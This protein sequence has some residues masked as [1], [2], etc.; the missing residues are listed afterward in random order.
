[1]KSSNERRSRRRAGAMPVRRRRGL[2]LA[3]ESLEDRALLAAMTFEVDTKLMGLDASKYSL[4]AMGSTFTASSATNWYMNES[5]S[6]V[7]GLPSEGRTHSYRVTDGSKISVLDDSIKGARIYFFV[8]PA[9]GVASAT[10]NEASFGYTGTTVDVTFSAPPA[11]GATAKGYA[12]LVASDHPTTDMNKVG[13]IVITD[14]GRGYTSPPTV[15]IAP[16]GVVDT[17]TVT[18]GGKD[19][20]NGQQSFTITSTNPL[21]PASVAVNVTGG[22]VPTGSATVTNRGGG[23][24]GAG[25]FTQPISISPS[26]SEG[27]ASV[28]LKSAATAT[29]T[30]FG[31]EG[32]SLP[33]AT[34][35]A[36][37]PDFPFVYQIVEFT[38]VTGEANT[39]DLQTVD[40]FTMPMT[41]TAGSSNVNDAQYQFGQPISTPQA[42]ANAAVT[43]GSILEA[44]DSFM[45][46]LGTAGQ[47]YQ[48]LPYVLPNG[49]IDG[50][51]GGILSPDLYLA[52]QS[53][54]GNYL[55]LGSALDTV[56]DEQLK[57]FFST[58]TD[59]NGKVGPLSVQGQGLHP[60]IYTG[61]YA[62]SVQYPGPPNAAPQTLHE[63][64]S[65]PIVHPAITFTG[66]DSRT[67]NVFSPIGLC[68][69]TDAAGNPLTGIVSAVNGAFPSQ[70][71]TIELE[72]PLPDDVQAGWFV[73]GSG[74]SQGGGNNQSAAISPW[75][76]SD[77]KPGRTT[78]S[79]AYT[80]LNGPVEGPAVQTT[81]ASQFQFSKLPYLSM[82][83]TPGQMAF[84]NSGVFADNT[85]QYDQNTDDAA[86]VANLE[87]QIAAA[88]NRGVLLAKS[89]STEPGSTSAT[90]FDETKW[91]PAGKA[92]NLFSYFM[93][94]GTV[95]DPQ[96]GDSVP[97][98]SRPVN[99][100]EIHGH[101]GV[102]KM[103]AA[104]GF[105]FDETP[106]AGYTQVPSKFD[107][108]IGGGQLPGDILVTFGPWGDVTPS[109]DPEVQA[110]GTF[111]IYA[112]TGPLAWTRAGKPLDV[113]LNVPSEEV[114]LVTMTASPT[115]AVPAPKFTWA[116]AAGVSATRV[117]DDR[118]IYL[119]GTRAAIVAALEQAVSPLGFD[120][121]VIPS[122]KTAVDLTISGWRK[123]ASSWTPF[124]TA[125]SVVSNVPVYPLVVDVPKVPQSAALDTP[126][127]L[128]LPHETFADTDPTANIHHIA[129]FSVS[130]SG[131]G[132][133]QFVYAS[134]VS[135]PSVTTWN[136]TGPMTG[137]TDGVAQSVSLFGTVEEI[138]RYVNAVGIRFKATR[139]GESKID[140][141][142]LRLAVSAT[143]GGWIVVDSK[144]D[145]LTVATGAA[146]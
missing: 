46:G 134:N 126:I 80:G 27:N 64:K 90:W 137:P 56:F 71:A 15:T 117:T 146:G 21:S 94:V 58:A 79:V 35:P 24:T 86:V 1:M 51:M 113:I 28:K 116:P 76:V 54:D 88:L 38:S 120:Y 68:R 139:D 105:P 25:S 69:L 112:E 75:Y 26:G 85:L 103:G 98:F 63:G 81:I 138:N 72:Q 39:V 107:Q 44:Y 83:L 53:V 111:K 13:S 10:V 8:V 42:P 73:F 2:A 141:T 93:H 118:V 135:G 123:P 78:V 48:K 40:G 109:T 4:Y 127:V 97:I 43:R 114:V 9:G 23:Y 82:M 124:D 18:D 29:A 106:G 36:N 102:A 55:H 31:N 70:T 115:S 133:G 108:N 3:V 132:T 30:L 84:G 144:T 16:P 89:A 45:E 6:F 74:L 99:P 91:Y 5:L 12:Q 104:Y 34:Q 131:G 11:G 61:T 92:Q 130:D 142:L 57:T 143:T 136:A 95:K 14:P 87:Y 119:Q 47:P 37:P 110:P 129:V 49:P 122:P 100:Q 52:A 128:D 77:V 41:I 65:V 66:A 22:A 19:Y 7:Q 125:F 62:A 145:E 101:Y 59:V 17:V 140:V 33:I 50:Q 67:F 96:S 121:S 20:P 32:P 60:Q